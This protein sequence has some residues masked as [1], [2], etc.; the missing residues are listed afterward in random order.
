MKL[1]IKIKTFRDQILPRII[2]KGDWIDLTYTGPGIH[3][4]AGGACMIGLDVAVKLPKG[5]EAIIVARSSTYKNYCI[6][7]PGALGIIDNR[8]C[9]N[10]DE[11]MF[12]IYATKETYI[13]SGS[14]LCQFRIQLSQKATFWQKLRWLFSNGVKIIQVDSLKDMNRG[15]LGSTGI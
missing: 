15:G 11:W 3:L 4:N 5:F 10:D 6:F 9:G 2:A 14:R 7:N 1:K 12:P 13:P 8:Y